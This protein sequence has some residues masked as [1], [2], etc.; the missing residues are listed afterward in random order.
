[1]PTTLRA[2][3][4][5]PDFVMRARTP[6]E[7]SQWD[8]PLAWAHNSDLLDP[9]PWLE[10]GGLLLTDGVQFGERV[11]VRRAQAY[12]TRLVDCGVV[13]LGFAVRIVHDQVPAVLVAAC[14]RIGLPLFEIGPRT[15]FMQIIRSVSDAVAAD[16]QERLERSLAAQRA[17]ARAAL[18]PDGLAAVLRELERNLGTWV[19]L[20]DAGGSRVRVPTH[21]SV[22]VELEQVA[23]RAA[24]ELLAGGRP[25]GA[26]LSDEGSGPITLQTLGQRGR[27][28]GVLAVGVG[29]GLDRAGTDL[30]TSVIALASIAVEQ[31]RAL[32]RS[33]RQLRSGAMELL[34]SGA[35][36]AARRT[37][38][39][40]W[41]D[42]PGEPIRVATVVAADGSTDAVLAALELL[43]DEQEG[44]V[45][46]AEADGAITVV[47]GTSGQRD[48]RTALRTY[49]AHAGFSA[50]A[51]WADF[52][53]A[54]AQAR[55]ALRRCDA[56]HPF[57]DFE[58]V[59][60]T[61]LLGHLETTGADQVA[62]RLLEP[63]DDEL[64]TTLRIW[65]EHNGS[66]DPT[67]KALGVH[68][69]TVRS[70]VDAASTLLGMDLNTFPARAEIWNA[71]QLVG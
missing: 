14:E 29:A 50:P 16:R 55:S 37:V 12:V 8:Q 1:M 52:E 68:R 9:T 28:L 48:V 51:R 46:F 7:D 4:A 45:F 44:Q 34:R 38:A 19:A 58:S 36:D 61:G 5:T 25:A 53:E 3:V 47:I 30:I 62:R 49:G 18:R 2:L 23:L 31:S 59:A 35:M 27:P 20:F 11:S 32:D 13:A 40:V 33:R 43:A 24:R 21:R 57:V 6:I 42:L 15:P 22:P 60:A 67:A 26:R 71:L 70:R 54:A 64:R 10:P 66:W 39:Q 41:G 17:V 63:L 69:H 65:L 56:K